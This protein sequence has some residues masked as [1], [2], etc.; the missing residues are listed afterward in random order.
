MSTERD[1]PTDGELDLQLT[2]M[3]RDASRQA[4][5]G[6]DVERAL[7]SV[8]AS[9]GAVGENIAGVEHL[10]RFAGAGSRRRGVLLASAAAAI[11][12]IVGVAVAV[13]G[14]ED[15]PRTLTPA[16]A[17]SPAPTT[18]AP[19]PESAPVAPSP[20]TS[21]AVDDSQPASTTGPPTASSVIVDD[22]PPTI[23][24]VPFATIE[25]FDNGGDEFVT[26]ASGS[27]EGVVV[28]QKG[29]IA[30]QIV[31]P[32][33]TGTLKLSEEIS[34]LVVGP[35]DVL[36]AVG[37]VALIDGQ[38]SM[39]FV[40]IP[41]SGPTAGTVVAE[42]LADWNQYL[43][44]PVG[45][46]MLGENGIVDQTR[47]VGST[48]MEYVDRSGEPLGPID[49]AGTPV[50]VDAM[51][52]YN[53]EP[54]DVALLGED[55]GWRIS[56]DEVSGD[57]GPTGPV[58]AWT[59][60]DGRVFVPVP[61]RDGTTLLATLDPDGSG[62]WIRLPADWRI[63]AQGPD[64]ATLVRDTGTTYEFASVDPEIDLRPVVPGQS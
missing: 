19:P 36:Y 55:P 20:V 2:T 30:A 11:A 32:D 43:E 40:A 51:A 38:P 7:A 17:P 42:S 57:L 34:P 15:A 8:Q 29:H 9:A 4:T 46:F 27:G 49:G 50:A 6:L 31:S 3:A 1:H 64:G 10:S 52:L 26:A 61:A 13:T 22:E 33:D 23:E 25:K 41:L 59:G 63:V 44:L 35:A 56:S 12:V 18:M 53:G 58:P 39:R 45:A 16:T 21:D 24:P 60:N 54:A 14:G 62:W 28:M 5:S 37:D 47:D 48:V